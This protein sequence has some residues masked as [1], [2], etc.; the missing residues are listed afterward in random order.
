MRFIKL[1]D[2]SIS[3]TYTVLDKRLVQFFPRMAPIVLVFNLIQNNFVGCIVTAV[4][5][6]S[7]KKK[8]THI[9][10][11]NFCVAILILKMEENKQHFLHIMLYYFK[12]SKNAIKMQNKICVV[13]GEGAV[14]D[15]MCQEW[16]AKF[17][18]GGFSL[19]DAPV[20]SRPVEVDSDHIRTLIEKNQHYTTWEIADI[21]KISIWHIENHLH[22]LGY[23]NCF[24]VWVPHKFSRKKKPSWPYFHMWFST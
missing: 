24:D 23:V 18:A 21:L 15:W 1:L 16:F 19:D 2:F 10:L 12:N 11:V 9:K 3:W 7:I 4:I 8:K 14:T 13:Y 20:S 17:R 6:V 22:Q 5:S